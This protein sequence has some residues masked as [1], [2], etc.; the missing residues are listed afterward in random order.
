M[1]NE[2][3]FAYS[4]MR[5]K[6]GII[7]GQAYYN[8][9]YKKYQVKIDGV[10]YGEHDDVEDAIDELKRSGFKAIQKY[11]RGGNIDPTEISE[12]VLSEIRTELKQNGLTI[13]NEFTNEDADYIEYYFDVDSVRFEGS[14]PKLKK[15]VEAI[16]DKYGLEIGFN[17]ERDNL[18]FFYKDNESFAKGGAIATRKTKTAADFKVGTPANYHTR[19]DGEQAGEIVMRDGKKTISLYPNRNYGGRDRIVI[20]PNKINWNHMESFADAAK[21][22]GEPFMFEKGGNLTVKINTPASKEYKYASILR[23]LSM[24]AYPK[25]NFVRLESNSNYPFG[26][27]AVYSE[28]LSLTKISH[29]DFFPITD[30]EPFVGKEMYYEYAVGEKVKVSLSDYDVVLTYDNGRG[31]KEYPMSAVDFLRDVEDGKYRLLEDNGSGNPIKHKADSILPE[32]KSFAPKQGFTEG[33]DLNKLFTELKSK[34]G[35]KKGNKLYQVAIRL[36]NPNKNTIIEIRGNGVV[37]KEGEKYIFKP[38]SNTDFH[39]KKWGL[40][41]DMDI[42]DQFVK[43]SSA[44]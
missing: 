37:V 4:E 36:V 18:F 31:T 39:D 43:S 24:G 17:L 41:N 15:V 2:D 7:V 5:T 38:F 14:N 9:Y 44:Q 23:P 6:D 21:R 32:I 13:N 40:H 1:V 29:F 3:V 11:A 30:L 22:A 16:A 10:I 26:A 20:D 27:V 35:D 34:Y 33:K 25:D 42:S 8:P 19:N 28:P 12:K